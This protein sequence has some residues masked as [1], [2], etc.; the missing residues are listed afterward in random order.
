MNKHS[1]GPWQV[2]EEIFDNEGQEEIVIESPMPYGERVV[3][4]V[5]LAGLDEQGANALL[6]C[7]APDLLA[8]AQHCEEM[9]MRHEIN[10]VNGEQIADEALALIRAAIAKANGLA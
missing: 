5:A 8:V 4:A 9:L 1:K 7:A 2:A 6:I 3:V 10:E